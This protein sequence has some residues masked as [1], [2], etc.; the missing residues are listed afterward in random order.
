MKTTESSRVRVW[1]SIILMIAVYVGG[2]YWAYKK[3]A[4]SSEPMA[5]LIPLGMSLAL[6]PLVLVTILAILSIIAKSGRYAARVREARVSPEIRETLANVVAG[7]GDRQ[8][9]RWLAEHY[10]RPFEA[11]FT[12]FLTSFGGQV[13]TELTT[14]ALELGLVKRWQRATRSRNFVTQKLALANLGRVRSS[15]DRHL[16]R[17]RVEQTRIEAA[18]ALLASG[19]TDGPALVFK[20][21]PDQSLLGRILL[22]DSL[23]PYAPELCEKYMPAAIRSSDVRY[24]RASMDL[25]HAWERWIPIA[26]FTSLVAEQDVDL[27]LAAV[28]AL[29]YATSTEEAARHVIDLLGH[30]DDRVHAKAAKAAADMGMAESIPLLVDRVRNGG[31]VSAS[32]AARALADLGFEGR[33]VLEKEI[34]T[35]PR[36]QFALHALEQ[37]LIA[38]RG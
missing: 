7:D 22:A 24:A 10:P 17:H 30:P 8:R 31:A 28:P 15:I 1:I 14:L 2:V 20:M 25:L 12:E 11:I 37:S 29:R 38:E 23:R 3:S 4:Q 26:S 34:L 36:P 9:L 18:S 33:E 21:L 19:S 35:G 16:L 27:R 5:R 13:K 6:V 32:A